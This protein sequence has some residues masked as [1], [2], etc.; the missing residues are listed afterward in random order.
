MNPPV[1]S[2]L[3]GSLPGTTNNSR[4]SP[5]LS[6]VESSFLWPSVWRSYRE[7]TMVKDAVSGDGNGIEAPQV[8]PVVDESTK[9][10]SSLHARA[11][12]DHHQ[13]H[14]AGEPLDAVSI[15]DGSS[16]IATD[17]MGP[18]GE[19]CHHFRAGLH[20]WIDKFMVRARLATYTAC[21][22]CVS[23]LSILFFLPLHRS[24][25]DYSCRWPWWRGFLLES[26]RLSPPKS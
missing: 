13:Q 5:L 22:I 16:I 1:F 17:T 26:S 21:R 9:L 10:Q 4:P 12:R 20:T 19:M 8:V 18:R 2:F 24:C 25:A 6:T 11:H 23:V 7:V 3:L 14:Q 15:D